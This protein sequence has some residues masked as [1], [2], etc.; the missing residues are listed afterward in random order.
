MR[1]I[2]RTRTDI[3]PKVWF[4]YAVWRWRRVAGVYVKEDVFR[5]L[6]KWICRICRRRRRHGFVARESHNLICHVSAKVRIAAVPSFVR[7]RIIIQEK[8]INNRVGSAR[9]K[10]TAQGGATWETGFISHGVC[11]EG[12]LNVC[13]PGEDHESVDGGN[14]IRCPR[15]PL[16]PIVSV[17][18][19]RH[20]RRRH[21]CT[22]CHRGVVYVVESGE[23][24]ASRR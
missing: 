4:R 20:S 2:S 17:P 3:V 10:G 15:I 13:Y 11:A 8:A 12:A 6:R 5:C 14:G 21:E 18:V 19:R 1:G 22:P 23:E 9:S 16:S 7:R 24:D